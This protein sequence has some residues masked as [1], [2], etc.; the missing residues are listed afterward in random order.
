MKKQI[1]IKQTKSNIFFVIMGRLLTYA[2]LYMG[3][4]AFL[5]W[6]FQQITIYK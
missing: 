3:A 4:I 1:K 6:A 5:F 2:F